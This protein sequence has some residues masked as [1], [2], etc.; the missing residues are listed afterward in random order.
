MFRNRM[1][2]GV[3]FLPFYRPDDG[4]GAGGGA[5]GAGDRAGGAAGGSAG[6]AGAGGAAGADAGSGGA[7]GGAGAGAGGAA[8]GA[9]ATAD[10]TLAGGGAAG[11]DAAAAAAAAAAAGPAKFSDKWR[12]ELA[13]GDAAALKDLAKYT[14]PTALYKSL[15]DVQAKISKG[16]LKAP[17]APLAKDATPEQAAEYRK[18]NGLPETAEGYVKGLALPDGVVIGKADEPLVGEFA[19]A[20][21]K[22]GATQGEM[23][24][25]VSWFYQQ[26]AVQEQQ[27][28]EADGQ[29][30]VASEVELRT[31]W[32]G[33]FKGNMN[34]VGSVLAL[35]PEDLKNDLLSARTATGQLV[36][37][38]AAFNRWAASLGRE[39]NPA[40][41]LIPAG[42]G[43][44]GKSVA[45]EIASIDTIYNKA[46]SGDREAH[47]AYYG[48]DGKPGL[49]VRQ[50]E[51][52]DAQ[53]KMQARG[54]AA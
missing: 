37:N 4:S 11:A 52:I 38:T 54:K 22:D 18:T 28:V 41:T 14:D 5:G 36:G 49:D 51:L 40:A 43:D 6:G 42:G 44:A 29:S 23:N 21:F 46:V 20:M 12:E 16:E 15:R 35:M 45:D 7:A 1:L 32:G 30:R 26:Q 25:A 34:A 39:L 27:R 17:P 31:E 3:S 33:D 24:R 50:R 10:K 53:Q 9:G 8:G 47:R 19:K 13:G 2:G 48:Y